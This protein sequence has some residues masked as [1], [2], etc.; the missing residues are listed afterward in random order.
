MEY[1]AGII[2]LILN[3]VSFF[4]YYTDKRRAKRHNTGF[5]KKCFYL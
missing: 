2:Y 4:V 1:T 5:R 3:F